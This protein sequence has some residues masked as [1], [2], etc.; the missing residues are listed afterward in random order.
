MKL[1]RAGGE[2]PFPVL[3]QRRET[4]IPVPPDAGNSPLIKKKPVYGKW[5]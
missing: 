2:P 3:D 5:A 4:R 1:G